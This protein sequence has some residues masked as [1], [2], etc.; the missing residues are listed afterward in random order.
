MSLHVEFYTNWALSLRIFFIYNVDDCSFYDQDKTALCRNV[1]LG[2][3]MSCDYVDL[4][5]Q[6][7]RSLGI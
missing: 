4:Q 5:T 7:K 1:C 6:K 3:W 2:L